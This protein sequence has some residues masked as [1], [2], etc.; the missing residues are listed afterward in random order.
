MSENNSFVN[1][2]DKSMNRS[3]SL[4]EYKPKENNQ[5]FNIKKVNTNINKSHRTTLNINKSNNNI[6]NRNYTSKGYEGKIKYGF[7]SK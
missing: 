7:K 1:I 6:I 2:N 5:K 3:I 4:I